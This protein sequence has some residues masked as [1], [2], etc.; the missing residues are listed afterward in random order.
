MSDRLNG[1]IK[2]ERLGLADQSPH[3]RIQ[4]GSRIED[5]QLHLNIGEELACQDH[6]KPEDIFYFAKI[7]GDVLQDNK[8]FEI[9]SRP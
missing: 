9:H 6:V 7:A 3:I 8:N 2:S 4:F 5:N 1:I